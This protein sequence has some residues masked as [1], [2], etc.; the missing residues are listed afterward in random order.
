MTY[1]NLSRR[2]D[3]AAPNWGTKLSR[4]GYH[5]AYRDFVQAAT[6][7]RDQSSSVCDVGT[8]SGAFAQAYLSLCQAPELLTLVDPAQKMLLRGAETLG[9]R[10]QE[11]QC[12]CETLEQHRPIAKYDTVLAAHVIEHSHNPATALR[13][14]WHLV[15]L[16]GALL[17][18]VSRPHWCQWLIWLRWQHRWFSS[19]KIKAMADDHDLPIPTIFRFQSGVPQRTSLGYSFFKPI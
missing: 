10:C 5:L 14:L 11:F 2:Y 6:Q 18:I 13:Q 12:H 19:N 4:H 8:G 15:A 3:A 17:L 1:T 16:G 9:G 7:G